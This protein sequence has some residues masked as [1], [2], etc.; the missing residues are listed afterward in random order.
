M[1]TLVH[2]RGQIELD[3]CLVMGIVNRTPDSFY[4]GH[5]D[6]V[7]AAEFAVR[8][9]EEGADILDIG[10]VKAGPGE[11]VTEPE[12]L[13]RLIPFLEGIA[14]R[15]S[16]PLSVETA[17]PEV[18]RRAIEVG[19]AIVNDVT[20][21]D[22]PSLAE[23]C[24]Q[25]GAALVVMH[26][27]D[28]LR[29]RPRWPRYDD[30]VKAVLEFWR[31]RAEIARRIGVPDEAIVVDPGLDF[32]KT[33]FHSLELVR[34]MDELV[35]DGH[36]VLV[37]HSRK[38]LIGETLDQPPDDRLAGGLAVAALSVAGG[39]ALVRTHD[40]E[41]TVSAVRMVEAVLGRRPPEAPVRGLWD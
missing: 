11:P 3:R 4:E 23:V 13:D 19:A 20:G 8:L 28:Q 9:V 33:T 6:M 2:A 35:A 22:D 24:A 14:D 26:H 1:R 36:P 30:V 18:A 38:D 29:G 5:P 21:L 37:A 40:V 31:E 12:E 10:A 27:G 17:R 39:A 16:V 25:T 32:G 34:R 7:D 41:L 15:V